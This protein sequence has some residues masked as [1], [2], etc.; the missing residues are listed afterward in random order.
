M[1]FNLLTWILKYINSIP[2]SPWAL[3]YVNFKF[4]IKFNV[5][6]NILRKYVK[7]QNWVTDL[8]NKVYIEQRRN[9]GRE[10]FK[11]SN[12]ISSISGTS[13]FKDHLNYIFSL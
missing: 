3:T 10:M 9:I 7:V 2:F 12:H 4:P 13:Q 8:K 1:W 5:A 6:T 11:P